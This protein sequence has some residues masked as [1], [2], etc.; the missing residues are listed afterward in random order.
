MALGADLPA[1]ALF[2]ALIARSTTGRKARFF[3]AVQQ[4]GYDKKFQCDAQPRKFFL[5]NARTPL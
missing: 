5:F 4:S 1:I 2:D 3:F